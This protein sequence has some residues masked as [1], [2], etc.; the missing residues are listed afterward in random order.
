MV[1]ESGGVLVPLTPAML[2]GSGA[3]PFTL[4]EVEVAHRGSQ[5]ILPLTLPVGL[6]PVVALGL[7]VQQVAAVRADLSPHNQVV[8]W[9]LWWGTAGTNAAQPGIYPLTMGGGTEAGFF[10]RQAVAPVALPELSLRL[11]AGTPPTVGKAL[12]TVSFYHA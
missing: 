12:V 10:A 1:V 9:H 6:R 4:L 3:S 11:Y 2:G 5:L 7:F 8:E